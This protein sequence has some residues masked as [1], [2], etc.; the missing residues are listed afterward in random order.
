[1]VNDIDQFGKWQPWQPCEVA[2]LF[3]SLSPC[4]LEHNFCRGEPNNVSSE[5]R[6]KWWCSGAVVQW[7]VPHKMYFSSHTFL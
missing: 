1:M 5:E 2:T 4:A 6:G 3:S 7:W